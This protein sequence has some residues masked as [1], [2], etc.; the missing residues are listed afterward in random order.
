MGGGAHMGHRRAGR[1]T[2]VAAALAALL[3]V[4]VQ[5]AP[6]IADPLVGPLPAGSNATMTLTSA[7]T[8]LANGAAVTFHVDTSGPTTLN[9]IE[10]HICSHA[11]PPSPPFINGAT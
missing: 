1:G 7:V 5:F 6:A 2:G 8:N 4:A 10:V 9:L 3:A 11:T